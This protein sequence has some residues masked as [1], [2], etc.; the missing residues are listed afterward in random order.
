MDI[1]GDGTVSRLEFEHRMKLCRWGED[2]LVC[3][4]EG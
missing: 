1:D 2:A 4:C 3:L